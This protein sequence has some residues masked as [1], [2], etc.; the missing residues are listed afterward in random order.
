MP[1]PTPTL[2]QHLDT[3]RD[4]SQGL[5]K[6]TLHAAADEVFARF[7]AYPRRHTDSHSTLVCA[8][9][10]FG[11]DMDTV[12]DLQ[13]L[14]RQRKVITEKVMFL[15]YRF[16]YDGEIAV[17]ERE[18]LLGARFV[19]VLELIS[20]MALLVRLHQR[21]MIVSNEAV[22]TGL[23]NAVYKWELEMT[24]T[25]AEVSRFQKVLLFLLKEAYSRNLRKYNGRM[26][27]QVSVS[28]PG[29]PLYKTHAW[30]VECE[31]ID[32]VYTTV[33]KEQEYE[34]WLNL[35]S[36]HSNVD[37]AV[38]YLKNCKDFELPT[39]EPNRHVFSFQNC[40]YDAE[41]NMVYEFGTPSCQIPSTM[42]AA[43]F[44]D[45]DFPIEY[46]DEAVD[47][48]TIPTPKVD[49][50]LNHQ[51]IPTEPHV[52]LRKRT[53]I[54]PDGARRT[55][56]V[57]DPSW[58]QL[59]VRD[60]FYVFIGR[61]I[62]EIGEYDEWQVLLF[63]KGVAGSGKSTLGKIVSYLYDAND[64]GV[65]SNN[66][67]KKFGLSALITK[68]IY[69]CFEVKSDFALDQG[70]FQ[71]MVSGEQMSIPF[72]FQTAQSVTWKSHGMFMGNELASWCD[73]SGSMSRRILLALFD[74]IV[75]DGNPKLLSELQAEMGHI[76]LKSNR[77]YREAADAFGCMDI[78]NVL[79]PY[80]A[81]NRRKLRA[82]THALAYFFE[83]SPDVVF[84]P[85]NFISLNDLKNAMNT[86]LAE[87][88]AF[89]AQK[90]G[91]TADFYQWVFDA[92]ELR[93]VLDTR[94]YRGS[95]Q[96]INYVVGVGMRSRAAAESAG[97]E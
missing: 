9:R 69:V 23:S 77:A 49:S 36:S 54:G 97:S 80:F 33:Q 24:N 39:L 72:K 8:H 68:L 2:D 50:I 86:F 15:Y 6:P 53:V 20:N 29:R 65:L 28:K 56:R 85:D 83:N 74:E 10:L 78:W 58:P 1:P 44:F 91:W 84:G 47:W 76:L 43:K 88:G 90:K 92:Y 67:E 38:T 19:R 16:V 4:F 93:I 70:E 81:H 87:D 31:V 82:E 18:S 89:R 34:M 14:E 66:T 96:T 60:W 12:V 51:K 64:V 40:V 35:T 13:D 62:Y 26:Y 95:M 57:V 42:V 45:I 27:R 79:P 61:M 5:D 30:E 52:A 22:S 7:L 73:N 21:N 37:A 11:L 25:E 17:K 71:C 75:T 32:F 63:I 55:E 94:D 3:I 46:A 48:R 59:S 41:E